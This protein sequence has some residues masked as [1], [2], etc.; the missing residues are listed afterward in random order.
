MKRRKFLKL[1]A[2]LGISPLMLNGIPLNSFATPGMIAMNCEGISERVLVIIQLAGGNDALNVV[3]PIDQI[4]TYSNIRPTIGIPEA[5]LI[6]LDTNLA[7]EDQVGLHPSMTAI[8]DLYDSGKANLIQAVSYDDNNRSHF[9]ATDL[10]LSGG[11]ST[12]PNFNIDT[13]WMG[14]YLSAT[15]PGQAGNPTPANPDPLG[16]QLGDSKPSLGF[17]TDEEHDAAINLSGQDP[18]GFYILISEIGGDPLE[19]VPASEYGDELTYIMNIENS[20]SNYAQRITDV[21]NAGTN[22]V[23]YP[24]YSL[25]NQLKTVA[26][27]ISGGSMT[28][29]FLV[30]MGGY[31]THVNQ[32]SSTDSTVGNHADLLLHLSESVKAF[33]D[34]LDAQNLADKVLSVSFSEFGRKAEENG[35]FGTDHGTLAPM[36]VFGNGIEPG[37][38][39]TNVD[40]GNLDNGQLQNHQHDYRQVFTT[41]LQ[42]WLGASDEVIIDTMFDPYLSQKLPIINID[43]LVDPSCYLA[44]PVVLSYFFARLDEEEENVVIKWETAS[45]TNSDYFDVERSADG[46]HFEKLTRVTAMGNSTTSNLYSELDE[47]PLMGTSY[48][49]LKQVDFDSSYTYSSIE[50]VHLN[51]K[52]VSGINV[53]PNP[54]AF[55]FKLVLTTE[56]NGMLNCKLTNTTGLRIIERDVEVR[57]GFNKFSFPV[58]KLMRGQYILQLFSEEL[59]IAESIK[60]MKV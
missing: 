28:K 29:V 13:G 41:L 42:D 21:F 46:I 44:L 11:D 51:N 16:I 54:A 17:H 38:T 5:N 36:F 47:S 45:E 27:L 22:S 35:N 52:Q 26:R 18:A 30:R 58:E 2:P 25:A 56:T 8:K 48:Y 31:D 24:S 1:A 59:R 3:I 49:R 40:L 20:V 23:T 14:R 53:Y 7:L 55:D 9:K 39:G 4:D 34:D 19:T 37:V 50:S 12:P 10:W 32:V 43:S 33:Q 60:V 6:N 57:K 15:F